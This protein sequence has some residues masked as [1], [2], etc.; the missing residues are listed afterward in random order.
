MWFN[1]W[2]LRPQTLVCQKLIVYKDWLQ[3][4]HI[5]VAHHWWSTKGRGHLFVP[6]VDAI[7][8]LLSNFGLD[9]AI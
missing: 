9:E 8:R 4:V 6:D 1:T 5:A 3:D 7:E 2:R